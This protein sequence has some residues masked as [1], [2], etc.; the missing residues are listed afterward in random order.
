MVSFTTGKVGDLGFVD[1][2]SPE[3][4]ALANPSIEDDF[5]ETPDN[6]KIEKIGNGISVSMRNKLAVNIMRAEIPLNIVDELN[7]HIDEVIIPDGQDLSGGL[8]GQINQNEKSAQW[9]FPHNY[10]VGDQ[11]AVVLNQLAKTYIKQTLADTGDDDKEIKTDI[12]TMWTVH[13]Y[14]GDYNPLHDHGTR[15]FMGL[16]CIL[17]L[18]VPPQIEAIGLPSDAM[19]ASGVT[20]GFQGINGASGAVDGFTYLCWGANGMRDVN[21]L[22]P[23]TEEYVKPEVGTMI[24]FPAWLRHAVMPFSGEGERR[25]F[26]ANINVYM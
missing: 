23:I 24:I 7:Q 1:P 21:M 14:A 19:I 26:S 8:V 6:T 12:Q 16:S 3:A 2:N 15:S 17:Y 13:S 4:K 5:V 10:G 11:F 20:P 25:T 22:R 9:L 18:K